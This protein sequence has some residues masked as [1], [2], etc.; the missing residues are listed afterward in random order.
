MN[1]KDYKKLELENQALKKLLKNLKS[2]NE[3]LRKRLKMVSQQI[4]YLLE[5]VDELKKESGSDEEV[6]LDMQEDFY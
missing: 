5:K 1:I 6:H 4:N 3:T 2:E